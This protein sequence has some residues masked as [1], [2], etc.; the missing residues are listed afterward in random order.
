MID[1]QKLTQK[2]LRKVRKWHAEWIEREVMKTFHW[3]APQDTFQ[4]FL[5]NANADPDEVAHLA[6]RCD[7]L[8]TWH[9][10]H[11]GHRLLNEGVADPVE[12]ALSARYAHAA[13]E[14]SQAQANRNRGG[15]IGDIAATVYL[16]QNVLCGWHEESASIGDALVKG[17]DTPML[18]LRLN[19]RHC[20]GELYPAFWF[21]VQLYCSARNQ[22]LDVSPY[23]YPKDMAPYAEVLANWRTNDEQTIRRWVSAMADY[24]LHDARSRPGDGMG[25]FDVEDLM[26]FPYEILFWL[27]L[28]EWAGLSNPES[29]DHPLMKLPTAQL[30]NPV[31]L[32]QPDTPLL[33]AVVAKF[34]LEYPSSFAR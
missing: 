33:D 2:Y 20:A 7:S 29:F 10:V 15:S 24:H 13:V 34:K 16:A 4:A 8:Q 22:P 31:P 32:P 9:M 1:A 25:Q 21:V 14:F 12:F 27:R 6:R 30:P 18:D 28:R 26:V 19:D 5:D 11:F 17:L 3:Q 23:S